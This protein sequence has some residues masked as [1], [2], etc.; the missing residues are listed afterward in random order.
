MAGKLRKGWLRR[1]LAGM[2]YE[3]DRETLTW[4]LTCGR[5]DC[6]ASAAWMIGGHNSGR[7]VVF[8]NRHAVE[9]C[10]RFQVEMPSELQDWFTEVSK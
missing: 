10:K 5:H 6:D 1:V 8:C 7:A 2:D 9:Y 4:G 3:Y